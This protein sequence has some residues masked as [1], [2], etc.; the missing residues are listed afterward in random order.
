MPFRPS[1]QFYVSGRAE[2]TSW[3][4]LVRAQYRPLEGSPAYAGLLSSTGRTRG[5]LMVAKWSR[6]SRFVVTADNA[7]ATGRSAWLPNATVSECC[8]VRTPPKVCI[9]MGHG[10][11]VTWSPDFS[12]RGWGG[13][14]RSIVARCGYMCLSG[15]SRG[16][17]RS[18]ACMARAVTGNGSGS[19]RSA[20][21][22]G[23]ACSPSICAATVNRAGSRLGRSKRMSQT[24]FRLSMRSISERRTGWVTRLVGGFW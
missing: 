7:A 15:E 19:S 12:Q 23:S 2:S 10:A 16:L 4:S 18:Y 6:P 14:A 5:V 22:R 8:F 21:S 3:G 20:G 17:H 24:C 11:S 9:E 13:T 1:W